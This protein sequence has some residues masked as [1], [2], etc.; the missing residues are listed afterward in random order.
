MATKNFNQARYIATPKTKTVNVKSDEDAL[1]IIVSDLSSLPQTKMSGSSWFIMCPFHSEYNNP[2][3]S[4]NINTSAIVPLGFFR[5]FG[6]GAKGN[7]NVLAQKLNL[8]LI[9]SWKISKEVTSTLSDDASQILKIID[10][11]QNNSEVM[12][13]SSQ[14]SQSVSESMQNTLR[15]MNIRLSALW[16]KYLDWRGFSGDFIKQLGTR[17]VLDEKKSRKNADLMESSAE[18]SMCDALFPVYINDILYG[19]VK[20]VSQ[21]NKSKEGFSPSYI[22][23]PGAWVKDN[24]LL[25]YDYAKSLIYASKIKRKK[26]LYVTEGPRDAMR[27]LQQGYSAVAIL[28]SKAMSVRKFTYMTL[29]PL[30]YLVVIPDNDSSGEELKYDF[31]DIVSDYECSNSLP[32]EVVYVDLP[33]KNELKV[34]PHSMSDKLFHKIVNMFI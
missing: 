20:G 25:F 8:T 6:C 19:I 23:S 28:G 7:W 22:T 13:F 34:D 15:S 16:P 24:G 2:S 32:F 14:L 33:R 21:N 27:F 5:C 10:D 12:N 9:E 18:I 30:D 3:C 1:S 11:F 29:L 26:T 31:M 17:I 4:V